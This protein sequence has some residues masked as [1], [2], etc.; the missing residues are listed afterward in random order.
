MRRILFI[1]SILFIFKINYS[2]KKYFQQ[3]VNT[4][5]EVALDD[6][7]HVLSAFEKIE[8]INNSTTKLDSIVIHLWPNAYK[9]IN[10]SLATRFRKW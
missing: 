9:N 6:N 3:K 5:I 4:T 2:Q 1:V 8:Y 7:K 10:T